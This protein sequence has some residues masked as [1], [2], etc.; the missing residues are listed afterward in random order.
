MF[1][2]LQPLS[3]PC[4]AAALRARLAAASPRTLRPP[5]RRTPS[6]LRAVAAAALCYALRA[7]AAWGCSAAGRAAAALRAWA[8]AAGCHRRCCVWLLL[9]HAAARC[10]TLLLCRARVH[11]RSKKIAVQHFY[12]NILNIL[13]FQFQHF[14]FTISTF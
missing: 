13:C 1:F 4:A 11:R 6:P 2:L 5:A 9:L 8:A 14:I 10:W 12:F 3:S 7:A